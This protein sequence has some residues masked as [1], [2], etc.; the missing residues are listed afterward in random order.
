[1]PKTQEAVMKENTDCMLLGRVVSQNRLIYHVLIGEEEK[2]GKVSGKLQYEALNQEDYPVVGDLVN[3]KENYDEVVIE[4]ILPRK[5]QIGRKVAGG[6][7]DMQVL[8][9]NM[10]KVFITMSL[11]NDFNIRRLERYLTLAWDSGAMPVILLTKADLCDDIEERLEEVQFACLGVDVFILSMVTGQGIEDLKQYIKKDE[12]VVFVGSSGVGKSSVVN[13]L[14][15]REEQRVYAIDEHDKG[16][17][18]T[19]HRELFALP[20]GGMVIDTPG[21]RELQLMSGDIETTFEDIEQLEGKCY[22]TNCTHQTEPG[23]VI[24]E[25]I[26]KEEISAER[27]SAYVKLKKEM[28]IHEARKRH[29]E[30]INLKKHSIRKKAKSTQKWDK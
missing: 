18:T 21:M 20:S 24:R 19:T 12:T 26:E 22:F 8:A 28:A 2:V 25:A 6:R 5:S 16:R 9:T 10:D 1:M 3:C 4:S 15:G 7:S 27:Y 30:K 29:K 14:L 13:A 17:H 23:C 11:N